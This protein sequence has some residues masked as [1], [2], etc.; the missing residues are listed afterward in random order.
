MAVPLMLTYLYPHVSTLKD[1][2]LALGGPSDPLAPESW[3]RILVA[4]QRKGVQLETM[5]AGSGNSSSYN[6]RQKSGATTSLLEYV[7]NT[8]RK[9][10]VK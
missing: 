6:V 1:T 5:F 10:S 4:C 8:A 2:V 3:E 7:L 9:V